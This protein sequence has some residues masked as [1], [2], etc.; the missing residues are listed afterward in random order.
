MLVTS[1]I[2]QA[3]QAYNTRKPSAFMRRPM[4]TKPSMASSL[5]MPAKASAIS[6]AISTAV[7]ATMP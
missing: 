3:M 6:S 4:P 2:T 5:S 7:E 1:H